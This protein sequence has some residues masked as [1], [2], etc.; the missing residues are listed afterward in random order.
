[1]LRRML[2]QAIKRGFPDAAQRVHL[3]LPLDLLLQH[4]QRPA[5]GLAKLPPISFTIGNLFEHAFY[6]LAHPLFHNFPQGSQ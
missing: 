2:F 6:S 3:H 5:D 4:I 1:M